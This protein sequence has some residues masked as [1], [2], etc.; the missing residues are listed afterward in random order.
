MNYVRSTGIVI[1]RFELVHK[2]T[3]LMPIEPKAWFKLH[4][5]QFKL[6]FLE[7]KLH[8]LEFACRC[9]VMN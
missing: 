4:F 1:A 6:H 2:L 5:L 3:S 8:F 9:A 7:F